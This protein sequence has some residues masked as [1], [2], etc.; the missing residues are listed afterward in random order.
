MKLIKLLPLIHTC[1]STGIHEDL[2]PMNTTNIMNLLKSIETDESDARGP[3]N[4]SF[5]SDHQVPSWL[6]IDYFLLSPAKMEFGDSVFNSLF[7]PSAFTMKYSIRDGQQAT[8]SGKFV[9]SKTYKRNKE[10]NKIVVTEGGT[11]GEPDD[12]FEGLRKHGD[13]LRKAVRRL[14][15]FFESQSD[16]S[17]IRM[18]F[19]NGYLLALTEQPGF[20]LIDPTTLDTV[21]NLNVNDAPN[22]PANL[23]VA[24]MSPHGFIADDDYFGDIVVMSSDVKVSYM[25]IKIPDVKAV[26]TPEELLAAMEFSEPVTIEDYTLQYFHSA[27]RNEDYYILPFGSMAVQPVVDMPIKLT[28]GKPYND[29]IVIHEDKDPVFVF[30]NM[31]TMKE[32]FRFTMPGPYICFHMINAW[33]NPENP[34]EMIMDAN[35]VAIDD[36]YHTMSVNP[37]GSFDIKCMN[38][39]G[40][41]LIDSFH[42]C[43][44]HG[45]PVRLTFNKK[46]GDMTRTPF[47]KNCHWEEE[48]IENCENSNFPSYDIHGEEMPMLLPS[49]YHKPGYKHFYSL[50]QG[51]LLWD[52]VYR[53][54]LETLDR[55][56]WMD[57]NN[58]FCAEVSPVEK[59]ENVEHEIETV[60]VTI[61]TPQERAEDKMFLV[62][63][64]GENLN[65][66]GRAYLPASERAPVMFH[67]MTLD[68][69]EWKSLDPN[70]WTESSTV[71]STTVEADPKNKPATSSDSMIS[72]AVLLSLLSFL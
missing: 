34:D 72:F 59:P 40:P 54:D 63:L 57:N 32:E 9:Q 30:V 35:Q 16:N 42:S 8:Y 6:N 51:T 45:N 7:D 36:A 23:T 61:C 62:V 64:D 69:N 46:T 68:R 43:T 29:A 37:Y 15:W 38:M 33:T 65:E 41:E 22:L 11:Y 26:R 60:V 56:V 2:Y 28:Q 39:T 49:Q 55:K 53:T 24:M 58:Y 19:V 13:F 44:F 21:A 71:Q 47:F 3:V 52:R 17:N 1:L 25:V 27:F 4:F 5:G 20:N 48:T 10:A 70:D 50:G 67:S 31:K 18:Q 66:L 12:I 14:E